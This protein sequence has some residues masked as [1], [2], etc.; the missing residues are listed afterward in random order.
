MIPVQ[1]NEDGVNE[2]HYKNC[3]ALCRVPVGDIPDLEAYLWTES[4]RIPVQ[5]KDADPSE[6]LLDISAT[7]RA[8]LHG[9]GEL[10][11]EVC[12]RTVHFLISGALRQAHETRIQILRNSPVKFVRHDTAAL[13]W[14]KTVS[15]LQVEWLLELRRLQEE[16]HQSEAHADFVQH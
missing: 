6:A 11:L 12:R 5:I 8:I 2:L 13:K 9:E 3:R 16:A 1:V 10:V 4:R 14:T 15:W 7:G